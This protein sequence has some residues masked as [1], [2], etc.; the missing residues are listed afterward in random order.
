MQFKQT[1]L[2]GA[3]SLF[4]SPLALSGASSTTSYQYN[5]QGNVTQIDGPRTDVQDI[6]QF[7]YNDKGQLAEV[8][9]ALGHS[10]QLSN[11]NVFG[12]PQKITDANG[13]VTHLSYDEMGQLT[14]SIIKSA[15][16]DITTRFEYDAIGQVTAVYLPNG[17]ELHYEYD[18]AKR[19]TAIQNGLGERIEYQHDNAGNITKQ[20]V[21]SSTGA[22]V[23]QFSQAYDEISRL[24]KSVGANGQTS[25]FEYDKNSN[26][27]GATNPRNYKS[28]NAYDA[29]NRL[30]TSTDAL[31]QNTQFKYDSQD[32]LTHVTD[33]RGVTTTYQ[34]DGLGR[35]VKEIS[36]SS[37]ETV[38]SHDA[39]GNITQKV[40]GR[41]V[42]T[43]YSYDALN[44]QTSRSY[45]ASPE[46]N[47]TYLYDG[48]ND[49]NKGIGRLTGIQ[50]QSGLIAYQYDDR[51][52][53][54]KTM[55]SVSLN[56]KDQFFGVA[57]GYNLANQLT[58]IQY[59]SGLTI[60][61]QRNSNGQV[62]QVTGQFKGSDQVINLAN[63]IGYVPFGPV[64]Q[65]TWGN[66][67]TLNRQYDQDLQL[68]QQTVQ[69]IQELNYQYDPNGNI[70]GIDNLLAQQNNS[71]Y[72][73]DALDRLI[74]EQANYGRKTYEYDPVGNRT[75][76]T[77][78]KAG[79]TETQKLTYAENSNRLIKHEESN[80]SY[81][82]MG[83]TQ[84]NGNGLQ[85][86]YD[87]QGRLK[88][89][90]KGGNT[91]AEY[92]YNAIG[93]RI[94]KELGNQTVIY[95]YDQNGQLLEEAYY[96][97]S[98]KLFYTR[99]YAWLGTQPIA[100]LE[101]WL[102][103]KGQSTKQQ[104][105][106]IHSDH[107]NT[108]RVA[109]NK[110]GQAIWQW[111]S[112][113]FGVGVANE[114]V[115]GNGQKTV[116]ALRFPGQV[117][118]PESGLHYNYYRD[119]DPTLGRYIESDPIGLNGGLNTYAYV[120]ANPVLYVDP[121][122]LVKCTCKAKNSGGVGE[123]NGVKQCA[124]SCTSEDGLEFN[125][126]GDGHNLTHGDVCRGA[127]WDT[128]VRGENLS[129]VTRSLDNFQVDTD[130]YWFW[131]SNFQKQTE[132]AYNKAKDSK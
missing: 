5:D 78:E 77:T 64:Q 6:T 88:A 65:L 106:Y 112:D 111:Q 102:N 34:Y 110:A 107:L 35:L 125:F 43:K 104:V 121:L 10:T 22:V 13:T 84:N 63:N 124:Y 2:A 82:G 28:G 1:L 119:Y 95:S 41:G 86:Q 4:I 105:A 89:V 33:P 46:L 7:S 126:T 19:L 117:F 101:Q 93:E 45:P 75:K 103:D 80:V 52:N 96:N 47:V 59:P 54:T 61:Y 18:G 48:T 113:A 91:Q 132:S 40:D 60:S 42:V 21:K 50:D 16:G 85:L 11:H 58:R 24:L 31:N 127:D 12:N 66:G 99:N 39:A 81:D 14:Q 123:V 87:G 51:G 70:T 15:A 36:P 8:V 108:P 71:S 79:K 17:S 92:R 73:Y 129:N 25:R 26:T 32:N 55:R 120:D 114:D 56:G 97:A 128:T 83:N 90:V 130:D 115:D 29:L 98:N 9:N 44:R 76:R 100:M 131:Q 118:D 57:Y 122:G 30:V 23:S 69:G 74:E 67:K 109:T 37:G 94:V 72:G 53:V 27:T 3:L 38:Y 116:V 62:N 68:I 20:V 49:G